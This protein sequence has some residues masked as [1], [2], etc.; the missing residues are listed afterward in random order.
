MQRSTIHQLV[1]P[2]GEAPAASSMYDVTAIEAVFAQA[3][4]RESSLSLLMLSTADGRA[5]AEAS[6]LDADGRRIAAMPTSF[7]T[8]AETVPRELT[9]READYAPPCTR[10]ANAC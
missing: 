8:P 3:R 7:L 2:Q 1:R 6:S 4:E 5:I 9:P 10:L